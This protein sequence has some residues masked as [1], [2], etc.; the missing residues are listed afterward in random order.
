M[1]LVKALMI[2]MSVWCLSAYQKIIYSSRNGIC[3]RKFS[4]IKDSLSVCWSK[5]KRRICVCKQ[6]DPQSTLSAWFFCYTSDSAR[7]H[8]KVKC[9]ILLLECRQCAHLPS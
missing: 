8:V 3:V 6:T 4:S 9:A 7:P 2:S 1:K 5:K